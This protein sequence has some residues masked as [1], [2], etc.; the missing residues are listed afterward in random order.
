M[1]IWRRHFNETRGQRCVDKNTEARKKKKK[2]S[3]LGFLRVR[4]VDF[5]SQRIFILFIFFFY[6]KDAYIEAQVHFM[7]FLEVLCLNIC[8]SLAFNWK[9]KDVCNQQARAEYPKAMFG[10]RLASKNEIDRNMSLGEKMLRGPRRF[11]IWPFSLFHSGFLNFYFQIWNIFFLFFFF[12][13]FRI[14]I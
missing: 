11:K 12:F 9:K 2:K 6:S 5:Y 14:S 8:Y 4:S 10:N 1:L 3:S 7:C 13:F